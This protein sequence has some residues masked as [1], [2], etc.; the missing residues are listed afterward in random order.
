M[1][2]HQ[3]EALDSLNV[4]MNYWWRSTPAWTGLP[5]DALLHALMSIGGLPKKQREAWA[6]LFYY[7]VVQREEAIETIPKDIHGVLV[8]QSVESGKALRS[9]LIDKLRKIR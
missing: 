6:D 7:Y 1:W 3:V 8:D 2:W 9:Y 5:Q 4:L